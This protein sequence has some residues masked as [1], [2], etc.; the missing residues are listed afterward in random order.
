MSD[1]PL[2]EPTRT[3]KA[4]DI[5]HDT[6]PARNH[7]NARRIPH[8]GHALLFFSLAIGCVLMV[9]LVVLIAV[10]AY[11]REAALQ[12]PF[13]LTMSLVLGYAITFAIAIP[14]FPILWR[15][16]FADGI[17]WTWRAARL[18]WWKLM[19]LG[20]VLS[21]IAQLSEHWAKSPVTTDVTQLLKTPAA[22]W[23]TVFFGTLVAPVS[24]EIAFRGFLLPALAT[25]YDWLSLER[26]PAGLQRWQRNTDHTRGAL[27]FG[28]LISSVAFTSIHSSQ[29]HGAHVALAVLFCMS[30][31][32]SAIRIVTRSV[33]ASTLTHMAYNGLIFIEVIIAT[34]GFHHLDKL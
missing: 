26:T 31:A 2:P 19:L 34:H 18:R 15:R 24:E 29:L 32:C 4:L 22:A 16:S 20:C 25:A 27:I 28:A 13:A 8:L 11:T 1:F 12:H 33:A 10:H 9:Q 23:L 30:L 6:D 17:S 3:D 14:I 7:G 21:I 5:Q